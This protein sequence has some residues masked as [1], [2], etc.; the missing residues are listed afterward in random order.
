MCLESNL[1]FTLIICRLHNCKNT[2]NN[3]MN[4]DLIDFSH[5]NGN[6]F[7]IFNKIS[8]FVFR[9]NLKKFQSLLHDFY[10][11]LFRINIE[12]TI[13]KSKICRSSY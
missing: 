5:Q 2:S 4:R 10:K 3:H 8:Y 12:K 13:D 9:R 11:E 6:I 7:T 1:K